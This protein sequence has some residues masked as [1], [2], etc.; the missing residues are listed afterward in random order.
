MTVKYKDALGT[1]VR[2]LFGVSGWSWNRHIGAAIPCF[3]ANLSCGDCEID[4]YCGE[5]AFEV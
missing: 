1:G 2:P 5:L 3:G 4:G